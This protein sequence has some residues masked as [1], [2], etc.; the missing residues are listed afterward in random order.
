MAT[1]P[2]RSGRRGDAQGVS[3][4]IPVSQALLKFGVSRSTFYELMKSGQLQKLGRVRERKTLV[5]GSQ[6]RRLL[7]CGESDEALPISL[8]SGAAVS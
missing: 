8:S 1:A 4:L 7:P 2:D 6:I 5:D 3:D